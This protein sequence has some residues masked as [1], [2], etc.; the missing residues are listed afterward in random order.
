[1]AH[2]SNSLDLGSLDDERKGEHHINAVTLLVLIDPPNSI[3]P[4]GD[5][6][7]P[8]RRR[9]ALDPSNPKS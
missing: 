8:P 4:A 7:A 6:A 1:M 2:N 5:L 3:R 9:A